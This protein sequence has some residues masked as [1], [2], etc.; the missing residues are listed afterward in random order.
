[1]SLQ[2]RPVCD[3]DCWT[4]YEWANDPDTR[5][6]SFRPEP[7]TPQEHRHWFRSKT[8]ADECWWWMLE[9]NGV[10][11]AV[12]RYDICGHEL[13]ANVTVAPEYRGNGYGTKILE[14]STR[15]ALQESGAKR[16]RAL[17]FVDNA[18]SV[19]SFERA[20]YERLGR[21]CFLLERMAT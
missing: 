10:P 1:M 8:H 3:A 4:L 9:A 5:A 2:I 7:I 11:V 13:E 15:L 20:G 19:K 17:V 18:G 12:A 21:E 14:I 16:C 6:N